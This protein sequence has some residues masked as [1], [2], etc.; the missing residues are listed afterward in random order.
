MKLKRLKPFRIV[1]SSTKSYSVCLPVNYLDERKSIFCGSIKF[2]KHTTHKPRK[3]YFSLLSLRVQSSANLHCSNYFPRK[4]HSQQFELTVSKKNYS[5][6]TIWE[7]K[8]NFQRSSLFVDH[9][10][11]RIKD[12][13]IKLKLSQ[14]KKYCTFVPFK[15]LIEFKIIFKDI[16]PA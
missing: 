6:G 15:L 10:P 3:I 16:R 13:F 9:T 11:I 8:W 5:V 4:R 2:E 1:N 7:N 14:E 12:S